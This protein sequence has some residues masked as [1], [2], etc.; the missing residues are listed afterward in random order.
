MKKLILIFSL[1]LSSTPAH[2]I[3]WKEFWKPFRY[4]R[5]YVYDRPY[6]R[7]CKKR[8]YREEYI[9]PTYWRSGYMRRWYDVVRVPCY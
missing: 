3:T 7:T 4:D 6:V 1:V 5:V 9:G 2:A 8:I